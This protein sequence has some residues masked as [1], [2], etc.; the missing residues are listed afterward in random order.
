MNL[1]CR[2][3]RMSSLDFEVGFS[4]VVVSIIK[5]CY[6]WHIACGIVQCNGH[7]RAART[8]RGGGIGRA[9][10]EQICSYSN[11]FKASIM[12]IYMGANGSF[13]FSQ[14]GTHLPHT[15]LRTRTN[16]RKAAAQII[17]SI[18][19]KWDIVND[20]PFPEGVERVW[21]EGGRKS[22]VVWSRNRRPYYSTI[23]NAES[24]Y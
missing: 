18:W 4:T 6:R 8:A 10:R 9:T 14:W 11:N 12:D 19:R 15:R 22:E 16:A 21:P 17:E 2:Y 5:A 13:A 3:L 24:R 20:R 23:P 1:S 7:T